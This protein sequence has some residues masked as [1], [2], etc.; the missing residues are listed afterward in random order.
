M[1]NRFGHQRCRRL[2]RR[3]G[4]GSEV[5]LCLDEILRLSRVR[6]IS[7]ISIRTSFDYLTD[8]AY[9][10][11]SGF[12]RLGPLDGLAWHRLS[13]VET[14]PIRGVGCTGVWVVIVWYGRTWRTLSGMLTG[15]ISGV[16][17][18]GVWGDIVIVWYGRT[19]RKLSDVLTG[20]V[21]GVGNTGVWGDYMRRLCEIQRNEI[22]GDSAEISAESLVPLFHFGKKGYSFRSGPD[23]G[24]MSGI[25]IGFA[26][27]FW[28]IRGGSFQSVLGDN[29]FLHKSKTNF[30]SDVKLVNHPEFTSNYSPRATDCT[31]S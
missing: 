16:G 2:W 26:L 3:M 24:V 21:R 1:L 13:G 10:A 20:P 14:G 28:K 8:I 15:P 27:G 23:I 11:L 29:D 30:L 17:C 6:R 12:D 19:W 4:E 25:S 9:C 18:T 7:Q 22:R 5:A 31:R